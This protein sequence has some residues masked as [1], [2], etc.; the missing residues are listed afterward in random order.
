MKLAG[1]AI[2]PILLALVAACVGLDKPLKSAGDDAPALAQAAD[3]RIAARLEAVLVPN[4]PGSWMQDAFWDEYLVTVRALG[5]EPVSITDVAVVDAL[6]QRSPT[7]ADRSG[8]QEST[9]ETQRRYEG[10]AQ[11]AHDDSGH[12]VV[13]GGVMGVATGAAIGAGS[14]IGSVMG[15]TASVP[16]A[17]GVMVIGGAL[18]V[19]VG[20]GHLANNA[21]VQ[22]VLTERRARLPV[23]VSR[24]EGV[25]LDL[26]FPVT[27][28]PR[29]IEIRYTAAG[30]RH[31]L[32][33]DTRAAL[34]Q[35]HR[36]APP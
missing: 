23:T 26:F 30:R 4:A 1:R 36:A 3:A 22:H 2:A 20:I 18:M 5:D 19:V 7:R 11:L 25:R 8:L 14:A 27:P 9:R 31:R 15:A 35:A 12:W 29:A 34:A 10:A 33:I 24:A 13:A 17:A 16:A 28:L 21:Q 6:G 32:L